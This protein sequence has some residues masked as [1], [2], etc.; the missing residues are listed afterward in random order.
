MIQR[1]FIY[2]PIGAFAISTKEIDELTNHLATISAGRPLVL[3]SIEVQ[4][5]KI[6]FA[7]ANTTELQSS[8]PWDLGVVRFSLQFQEETDNSPDAKDT[9]HICIFGGGF[10]NNNVQIVG[11][12]PAWADGASVFVDKVMQK[13]RFWYSPLTKHFAIMGVSWIAVF[14]AI[15]FFLAEMASLIV[16]S[17]NLY[18]LLTTIAVP[19]LA[20]VGAWYICGYFFKSRL[21]EQKPRHPNLTSIITVLGT[22]PAAAVAIFEL[23]DRI[24]Q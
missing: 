23:I 16:P 21:C 1:A 20:A 15:I 7:Y 14:L 8:R 12:D 13:Y 18:E 5:P 17:G 24:S 11:D 4:T 6:Q 2:R 9:R 3:G 22:V 10:M 19:G